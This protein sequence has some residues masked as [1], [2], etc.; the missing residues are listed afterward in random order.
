MD[1]IAR[2]KFAGGDVNILAI[3]GDIV[4][5]AVLLAIGFMSVEIVD[6]LT[7]EGDCE[8]DDDRA[9]GCGRI[10]GRNIA[11]E[12]ETANDDEIKVHKAAEMREKDK[13]EKSGNRVL[14][15]D[16]FVVP[17]L[18]HKKGIAR[19]DVAFFCLGFLEAPHWVVA[20]EKVNG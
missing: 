17:I 10:H 3:P 16:Y 14:A 8:D 13:R 1:D 5:A 4:L 19:F 11:P 9:P 12:L 7:D 20:S 2:I 6:T 15:V 18:L